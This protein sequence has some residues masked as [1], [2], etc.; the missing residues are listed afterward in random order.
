MLSRYEICKIV[1]LRS[2][3][4][5]EESHSQQ[6]DCPYSIA[7]RELLERRLEGK[8]VRYTTGGKSTTHVISELD[9]NPDEI[10]DMF[11]SLLVRK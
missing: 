8:V 6:N 5:C 7:V 1:G 10:K 9:F 2:L 3:Q 4:I 11:H